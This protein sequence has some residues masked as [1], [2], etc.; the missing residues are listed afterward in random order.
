M[1]IL[2][3]FQPN[4]KRPDLS[5]FCSKVEMFLKVNE[6]PYEG[7]TAMPNKAPKGKLPTLLDDKD[8]IADSELIIRHL[9]EKFQIDPEPGMTPEQK[10]IAFM[11]RKT[12]EEHYYFIMLHTRWVDPKGWTVVNKLFFS[13]LPKPL[14]IVVPGIVR[15]QVTKGLLAQ[16]IGRH[17]DPEI[18]RR[19]REVL[20]HLSQFIGKSD[21]IFGDQPTLVD[22]VVFPYLW[23]A[24][25]FPTDSELKRVAEANPKFKLYVDRILKRYYS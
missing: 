24:F 23:G 25:N 19:G 14:R 3:Q 18:S 8:L 12:M 16:G 20:E 22:C 6:L 15:K 5:T 2:N 17:E 1:L 10:A 13:A 9:C 7:N 21:Y 4:P 11:I